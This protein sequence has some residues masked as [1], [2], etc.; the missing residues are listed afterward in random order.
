MKILMIDDDL[1]FRE[2]LKIILERKGYEVVESSSGERG[3]Q[4]L[5]NNEFDI[6]LTDMRMSGISGIKVLEFISGMDESERMKPD[7]IMITG[8]GSIENAVE[9][10]RKGAFSYFIKSNNP[11]ELIFEIEKIAKMRRLALENTRLKREYAQSDYMLKSDNPIFSEVIRAAE[12][13]ASTDANVLLLGE[14]GVGKEVIA[15]YIHQCS[16]RGGDVFVPVNCY[17]FSESMIEA[18]LYGH[19]KGSFTG[20]VTSRIGRFEAANGGTLFLDEIGEMPLST[21]IKLL[22][23]I[24]NKEIE[25]IGSNQILK[26]DFRL[27]SATNKNLEEAISTRM[28]REDLYY[29]INTVILEIPPLRSRK[30][31]IPLL[32][33][34]FLMRAKRDMKKQAVGM[35]NELLQT[36]YHYDY[37]GNIRELKNIVERL[38]VFSEGNVM[39]IEDLKKNR[40][41]A[42]GDASISKGHLTLREVRCKAERAYIQ[43]VLKA[44]DFDYDVSATILGISTRQLYNK[45][46]EYQLTES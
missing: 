40:I 1:D 34:Y 25:R 6:V 24:E 15:R 3:I 27:I 28:F 4:L 22:R 38:L 16:R 29:R 45:I 31:D 19:E 46:R 8:Y 21:Q 30:E 9:A 26:V 17:A 23:N 7:C 37:P 44:N 10:I 13:V 5:E 12:K 20:A 18:E 35:T 33:E 39:T 43:E 36:L 41:I 2:L 14:S 32:I 42:G 11:E